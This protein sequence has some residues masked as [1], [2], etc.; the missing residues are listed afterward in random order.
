MQTKSS[1]G[2]L[3]RLNAGGLAPLLCEAVLL[4]FLGESM[5]LRCPFF[6]TPITE[7]RLWR[8]TRGRLFG[9]QAEQG[10]FTHASCSHGESMEERPLVGPPR[11]WIRQGLRGKKLLRLALMRA[12]ICASLQ[13][14]PKGHIGPCICAACPRILVCGCFAEIYILLA[15]RLCGPASDC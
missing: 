10:G 3:T 4:R 6:L 1:A 12:C 5:T 13:C 15:E 2:E 9:M 14:C 8:I 11:W 7:A